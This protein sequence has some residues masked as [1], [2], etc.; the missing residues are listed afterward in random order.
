MSR[1]SNIKYEQKYYWTAKKPVQ[2]NNMFLAEDWNKFQLISDCVS[3]V[4]NLSCVLTSDFG[5]PIKISNTLT[6]L[7]ND[8]FPSVS[9]LSTVNNY[10]NHSMSGISTIKI[11][12]VISCGTI[13]A[14]YLSAGTTLVNTLNGKTGD[15]NNILT[16]IK[17]N[18]ETTPRT[19]RE[20]SLGNYFKSNEIV[21]SNINGT[22]SGDLWCLSTLTINDMKYDILDQQ[23]YLTIN[24]NFG[25]NLFK[26][27]ETLPL[28][29]TP[30]PT[31]INQTSIVNIQMFKRVYQISAVVEKDEEITL[32]NVVDWI[33][34]TDQ[35]HNII[36]PTS[37]TLVNNTLTLT[38]PSA[39]IIY[40]LSK[41]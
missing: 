26:F 22:M 27:N 11:N 7:T 10:S 21:V 15:I 25:R 34:I 37:A 30:T 32:N 33:C 40:Y 5:K 35:N 28:A 13:N 36:L 12:D 16:G 19:G 6:S 24:D 2:L 39:G 3:A 1:I 18:D 17:I 8:I 38:S 29:T 23:Y 31:N 4:I 41:I 14:Y 20:V 9:Y